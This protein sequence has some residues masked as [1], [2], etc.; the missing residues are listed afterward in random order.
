M[1]DKDLDRMTRA[2]TLINDPLYKEAWEYTYQRIHQEIDDT[3]QDD[4]ERL[5][6][7]RQ[8]LTVRG[9]LKAFFEEVLSSGTVVA[10]RLEQER[11]GIGNILGDKW[12]RRKRS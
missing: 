11:K 6:K 4:V 5:V 10:F 9:M 8:M 2:D 12:K 7:L 3:S 1:S